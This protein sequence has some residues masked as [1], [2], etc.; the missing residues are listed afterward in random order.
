MDEE[1]PEVH[2][3]PFGP[4]VLQRE[5]ASGGMAT[6]YEATRVGDQGFVRRVAIKRIHPHLARDRA[7]VDMFLDEARIAARIT[8]P[9]VC[10]VVDYGRID[11]VSFLA[12]EFLHGKSLG[13]VFAALAHRATRGSDHV[14][15]VASV[16][17]EAAEGL[18][19][20]H[21]L[22]DESGSPLDVVH[23]DVSPQNLFLTFDGEVKVVDFGIASARDKTHHTQTGEIKG[24]LAYMAPEQMAG[25]VDRRSDV[26]ALGIV[27][28]EALALRRLF[29]RN[30]QAETVIAVERDVI[31]PPSSARPELTGALDAVTL[32]ALARDVEAR[33]P[34]AR[35]LATALTQA[36][37]PLGGPMSRHERAETMKAL[38]GDV[39]LL[40][41]A[42]ITTPTS[43]RRPRSAVIE[44]AP[45]VTDDVEHGAFELGADEEA[46]RVD[47][48]PGRSSEGPTGEVSPP[49]D[50]L[51][52][53]RTPWLALGAIAAVAVGGGLWWTFAG[54]AA[55]ATAT[56][57]PEPTRPAVAVDAATAVDAA[58]A[59]VPTPIDAPA[60]D[61]AT[62]PDGGTRAAGARGRRGAVESTGATTREL[63]PP[64]PSATPEPAVTT[65][66]AAPTSGR[67]RVTVPMGVAV[68]FDHA[69]ADEASATFGPR[70]QPI[71]AGPHRV[72]YLRPSGAATTTI[73][74]PPNGTTI[75]PV[76]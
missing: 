14:R 21:E 59:V 61:A 69:C 72:F 26:W 3:E 1:V 24:K 2:A 15:F 27:L 63:E 19:A 37:A 6:V 9:N 52:P 7:F 20:A 28:W 16:V 34:S 70:S 44:R 39:P 74:V 73:E 30:S 25:S 11:G 29:K 35:A 40:P 4:Y 18:H 62:D 51:P 71:G 5:L 60:V 48:R 42:S 36:L 33:F 55:P 54:P 58:P 45:M 76:P 31:A 23:R 41:P 32:E 64:G 13:Q 68:C 47:G 67:G 8:H 46:T 65:P 56:S 66:S 49:N 17:L 50:V 10:Q 38:F 57:T 22:T 12:M 43:E 53:T 75:I